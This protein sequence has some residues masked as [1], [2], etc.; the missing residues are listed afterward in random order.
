MHLG[1]DSWQNLDSTLIFCFKSFQRTTVNQCSQDY[2]NFVLFDTHFLFHEE[3]KLIISIDRL[4]SFEKF[5]VAASV[6]YHFDK[7]HSY[8]KY[9]NI[10]G[11]KRVYVHKVNRG[12]K[13]QIFLNVF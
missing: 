8:K 6:L 9:H 11:E 2:I 1:L 13:I 12:G 3:D 5:G 7:Q 4:K 10:S